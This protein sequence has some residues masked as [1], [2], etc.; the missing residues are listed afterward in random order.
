MRGMDPSP[1]PSAIPPS[2]KVAETGPYLSSLAEQALRVPGGWASQISRQ[3][4]HEGGKFVSPT[5]P[6][7]FTPR[8]YYWYLFLLEAELTAGP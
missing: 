8:K 2:R 6:A 3:S 5:H 1:L 7:A 4:A